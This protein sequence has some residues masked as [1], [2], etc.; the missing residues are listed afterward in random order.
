[1]EAI[2]F[3]NTREP[4]TP[5]ALNKIS[6]SSLRHDSVEVGLEELST[7]RGLAIS[8]QVVMVSAQHVGELMAEGVSGR[9]GTHHAEGG[10]TSIPSLQV[11]AGT[12]VWHMSTTQTCE[13]LKGKQYACRNMFFFTSVCKKVCIN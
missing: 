10:S 5:L 3:E 4:L 1:M 11:G 9:G 2:I 6:E 13:C 12:Q 7:G 8:I